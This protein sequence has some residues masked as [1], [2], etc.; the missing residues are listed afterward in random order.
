MRLES[1]RHFDTERLIKQLKEWRKEREKLITELEGM[2]ELPSV[3]NPTGVRSSEISKPAENMAVR[4]LEI[5]TE[6]TDIDECI[7]VYEY[8][9]AQLSPEER[10]VFTRF[11]EP[12]KPIWK[13]IDEYTHGNYTNRIEMYRRRWRIL[14]KMDKIIEDKFF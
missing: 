1:C 4:R 9:K 3:N 6:I 5:E 11:F 13:E 14:D 12:T 10:E 7:G 8:A 2:S